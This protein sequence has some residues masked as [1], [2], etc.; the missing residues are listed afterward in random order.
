LGKC[1]RIDI[2]PRTMSNGG[3]WGRGLLSLKN[4]TS[5]GKR[6][7]LP[8]VPAGG[9]KGRV[10]AFCDRRG[11]IGEKKGRNNCPRKRGFGRAS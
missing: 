2:V 4:L 8:Q 11:R 10:G 6:K 5:E 9:V 7:E 3:V 1:Q